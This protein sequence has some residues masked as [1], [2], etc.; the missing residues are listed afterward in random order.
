[1]E[2]KTKRLVT[3]VGAAIALSGAAGVAVMLHE[4]DLPS[5]LAAAP[6]RASAPVRDTPPALETAPAAAPA[7]AADP[8]PTGATGSPATG[9]AT[10]PAAAPSRGDPPSA[11]RPTVGALDEA[12]LH[13]LFDTLEAR[14]RAKGHVT[15][16][17]IEA[18]LA[19]I[20]Q[21]QS[22]LGPEKSRALRQEFKSRMAKLSAELQAH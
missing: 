12:S 20:E 1:M 18:G 4:R 2:A 7:P 8:A 13:R 6:P 21:S 10:A 15:P 3:A 5:P 9:E 17:E 14:A 22:R 11:A 19:A 16:I